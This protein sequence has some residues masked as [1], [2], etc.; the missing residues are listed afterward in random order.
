MI[1]PVLIR[2]K[3]VPEVLFLK[4]IAVL[5]FE[6]VV[7]VAEL[8]TLLAVLIVNNLKSAIKPTI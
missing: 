3:L 8:A 7:V 1:F 5:V 6:L 2:P 4:T